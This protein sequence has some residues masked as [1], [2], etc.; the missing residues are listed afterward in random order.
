M[1]IGSSRAKRL[2]SAGLLTSLLIAT[3]L[4]WDQDR[5]RARTSS[6]NVEIAGARSR[7]M[8]IARQPNRVRSLVSHWRGSAALLASAPPALLLLRWGSPADVA[9]LNL[10][11][12]SGLLLL[13]RSPPSALL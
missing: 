1:P 12:L 5:V 13:G 4:P 7:L 3:G 2:V 9:R 11:F 6:H 8:S 10:R